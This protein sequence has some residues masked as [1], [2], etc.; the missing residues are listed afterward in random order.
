ME[1]SFFGKSK[2]CKEEFLYQEKIKENKWIGKMFKEKGMMDKYQYFVNHHR[3]VEY[4]VSFEILPVVSAVHK[5]VGAQSVSDYLY[6]IPNDM[7]AILKFSQKESVYLGDVG[8][9]LFKWTGGC[10]WNNY[11]Y[12]F[13]RSSSRLLKMSLVTEEVRYVD[14]KEKYPR[15]HHYGGICTRDGIVYQAPR[16]SDHILVWDLKKEESK[17][18]YLIP[19]GKE[20]R[21]CGGVLHPNGFIYFFPERGERVIKVNI[22]TGKWTFIGEQI[23]TMVFDAKIAVDGNIYGYSAY[24]PGILKIDVGKDHVEMIHREIMP[25]AYGTKLGINGHLYSIPGDGKFVWDYDPL[26]DSLKSIYRFF[27]DQE[28]KFAGGVSMENGHIYGAPAKENRLLR[29]EPR[30][31]NLR[32]PEDVYLEYFCDCY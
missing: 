12:G 10:I 2:V 17:K 13:P 27:E 29:I 28:A 25:G 5:W 6:C 19:R 22:K 20:Y 3:N 26:T 16:D 32:I 15:E 30:N 18:I 4:Y 24:C 7:N 23:E 9:E 21:Y 14:L 11:L 31:C 8:N 1:K